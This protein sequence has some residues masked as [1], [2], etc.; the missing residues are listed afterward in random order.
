[1]TMTLT[2]NMTMTMNTYYEIWYL[3]KALNL[4]PVLE[5]YTYLRVT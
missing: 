2:I 3:Y 5:H 4:V 1:M